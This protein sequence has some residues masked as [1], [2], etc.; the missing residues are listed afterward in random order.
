MPEKKIFEE[1]L[2]NYGLSKIRL[3]QSYVVMKRYDHCVWIYYHQNGICIDI[4]LPHCFCIPKYVSE[5][6]KLYFS[7]FFGFMFL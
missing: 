7:Q 5:P 1:T 4:L 2:G 6:C 3:L